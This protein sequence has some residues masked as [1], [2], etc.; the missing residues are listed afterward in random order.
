MHLRSTQLCKLPL[1]KVRFKE[2]GKGANVHPLAIVMIEYPLW[3]FDFISLI[4]VREREH[5]RVYIWICWLR[6]SLPRFVG[7]NAKD[8]LCLRSYNY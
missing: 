5:K 4:S 2:E 1:L 7:Y 8:I 3:N 6:L